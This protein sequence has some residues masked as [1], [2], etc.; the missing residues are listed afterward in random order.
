MLAVLPRVLGHHHAILVQHRRA[1]RPPFWLFPRWLVPA[2]ITP[3][4]LVHNFASSYTSWPTAAAQSRKSALMGIVSVM[5]PSMR[6][7]SPVM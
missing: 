3:G 5:P 2:I 1:H 4:D 7:V 6:I